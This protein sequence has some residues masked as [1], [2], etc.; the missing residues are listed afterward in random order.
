MAGYIDVKEFFVDGRNPEASHVLLHI[1]EPANPK[2]ME[3]GYFFALADFQN[4]HR[5]IIQLFQE[6]IDKAERH[7]YSL[8]GDNYG[9]LFEQTLSIL[10]GKI[11][12]DLNPED[13][14]SMTCLI[15]VLRDGEIA[16]THHGS[17]RALLFFEGKERYDHTSILD[18]NS[19]QDRSGDFLPYVVSGKLS[20]NDTVAIATA[21]TQDFFSD[22]RL[23]KIITTR[24]IAEAGAHLE[25]ILGDVD[26]SQAFGGVLFRMLP[27]K[28][29]PKTG[30]LPA[31][32]K[33]GSVTSLNSLFDAQEQT[34]RTLAPPIFEAMKRQFRGEGE[35]EEVHHPRFEN[36]QQKILIL[37]GRGIVAIGQTLWRALFVLITTIARLFAAIVILISNKNN[38]RNSL[39]RKYR[40]WFAFH[41]GRFRALSPTSK[42]LFSLVVVFAIVFISSIVFMKLR[43]YKDATEVA[44]AA[45]LAAIE[46]KVEAGTASLL[47]HDTQKAT[48]LF[49][50]AAIDLSQLPADSNKDIDAKKQELTKTIETKLF[51][52]RGVTMITPELIVPVPKTKQQL[53]FH[54]GTLLA[55]GEGPEAYRIDVAAKNAIAVDSAV[56]GT[57]KDAAPGV[58]DGDVYLLRDTTA[59]ALYSHETK[60]ISEREITPGTPTATYRSIDLYNEKLYALDTAGN[61]VYK[62]NRTQLGFDKGTAWITAGAPDLSDAVSV[63]VDG[64]IYVLRS[65]GDILRFFRG[66]PKPI[67]LDVVDPVLTAPTQLVTDAALDRLFILEPKEKRILIFAKTGKLIAQL[68][69]EEFSNPTAIAL[70]AKDKVLYVLNDQNVF[71]VD[72]SKF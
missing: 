45:Q 50:S 31:R 28:M 15:G 47:Y 39:L 34:A 8:D 30:K 54:V 69:A 57:L 33:Q 38:A 3:K 21:N 52:L 55:F 63:S 14:Q 36:K 49:K 20:L 17:M 24:T 70:N 60:S 56:F 22:D 43:E 67:T 58:V 42:I 68:M 40:E 32:A 1:A 51:E 11:A 2:E 64:D 66:T 4:T 46:S 7:Y 5:N 25:R 41:I 6:L 16:V 18:D 48:S 37:F 9:D 65:R 27:E 53:A 61:Q 44:A 10:N 72:L 59:L 71:R 26:A 19:G 23:G 13:A 62:H 12:S 29:A 35:K